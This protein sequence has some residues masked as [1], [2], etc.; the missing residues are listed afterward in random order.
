MDWYAVVEEA[1]KVQRRNWQTEWKGIE[2][3]DAD[4]GA[5][6]ALKQARP[7]VAHKNEALEACSVGEAA[8][9]S[10]VVAVA[11]ATDVSSSPSRQTRQGEVA[12]TS[13]CHLAQRA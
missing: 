13:P 6:F 10:E 1:L 9:M 2:S 3:A 8:P 7:S 12:R 5:D 11:E 4:A